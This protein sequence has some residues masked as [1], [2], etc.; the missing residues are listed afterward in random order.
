MAASHFS[1]FGS[2]QKVLVEAKTETNSGDTT[3]GKQQSRRR[4]KTAVARM[5]CCGSVND[6]S[7]DGSVRPGFATGLGRIPVF[8]ILAKA[9]GTAPSSDDAACG[10]VGRHVHNDGELVA[11]L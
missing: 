3:G 10:Q 2:T 6:G 7:S 5:A 8:F 9:A 1:C 4:S 11:T